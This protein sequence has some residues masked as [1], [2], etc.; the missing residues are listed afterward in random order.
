MGNLVNLERVSK[1]YGVRPLLTDVSLG[2]WPAS[3]SA[4]S[5]ATATAR[6]PCFDC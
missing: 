2:V 4:S 1:A 3:G 6:P 5:G